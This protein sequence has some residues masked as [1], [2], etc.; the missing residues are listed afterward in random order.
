MNCN[1]TEMFLWYLEYKSWFAKEGRGEL[2][3]FAEFV[4]E[5]YEYAARIY[6]F[7]RF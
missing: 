4:T 5:Q 3:T 2:L 7:L 6:A 1:P